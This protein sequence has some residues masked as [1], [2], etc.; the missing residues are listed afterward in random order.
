MLAGNTQTEY[1]DMGFSNPLFLDIQERLL[2]IKALSEDSK[3]RAENLKEINVITKCSL[4]SI[5]YAL[6]AIRAN[7]TQLPLTTFSAS[8]VAHRVKS[9]LSVLARVYGVELCLDSSPKLDPIFANEMAVRGSL[10]G[11][12]A[13]LLLSNVS[14]VERS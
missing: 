10:S 5:E 4:Q 7:Q 13:T 12:V 1:G 9:E 2:Q 8:A 14:M 11:L 3:N 6:F